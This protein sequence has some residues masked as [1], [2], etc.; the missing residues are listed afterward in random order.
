MRERGKYDEKALEILLNFC[1]LEVQLIGMA[2]KN[3]LLH[4]RAAGKYYRRIFFMKK[5]IALL[6]ALVLA[7]SMVACASTMYR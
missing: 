4:V 1:K 7:L 5:I 3:G 2:A 6:L